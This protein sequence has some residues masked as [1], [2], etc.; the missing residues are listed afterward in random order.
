M[1]KGRQG[2]G[3]RE[4]GMVWRMGEEHDFFRRIWL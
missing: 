4:S 3:R 2:V 1:G